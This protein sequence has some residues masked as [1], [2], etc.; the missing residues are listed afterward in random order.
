[1]NKKLNLKGVFILKPLEVLNK[2]SLPRPKF[3]LKSFRIKRTFKFILN[4]EK[5]NN[6]QKKKNLFEMKYMFYIKQ[7]SIVMNTNIKVIYIT[8]YIW[9][10]I[11][12]FI[13]INGVK[14]VTHS[15]N[16]K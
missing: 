3:E 14:I 11:Q 12:I 13:K 9:Q 10:E 4:V 2:R 6:L 15:V 5:K 1:M 8:K 7:H 16:I